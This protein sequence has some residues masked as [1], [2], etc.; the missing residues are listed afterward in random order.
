MEW[1]GEIVNYSCEGLEMVVNPLTAR[2][3]DPSAFTS[4]FCF[5]QPLSPLQ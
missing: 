2:D 1:D 5:L 4:Y 3:Q